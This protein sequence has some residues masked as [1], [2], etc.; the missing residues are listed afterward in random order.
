MLDLKSGVA[1]QI[2]DIQPKAHAT[3]CHAHSLSLCVKD[4]TSNSKVLSDAMYIAIELDLWLSA[5][6][7]EKNCLVVLKI[8]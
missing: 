2:C 6:Q 7:R 4:T 5:P 3:H 1:K 8:T